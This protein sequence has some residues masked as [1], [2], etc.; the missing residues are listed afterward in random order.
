MQL[1]ID[2][3]VE[4]QILNQSGM[5]GPRLVNRAYCPLKTF[6]RPQLW[7][8]QLQRYMANSL[9]HK[10][11]KPVSIFCLAELDQLQNPIF[12]KVIENKQEKEVRSQF[13]H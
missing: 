7:T 4:N 8:E 11:L 13:V 9:T 12:F 1:Q 5:L 10:D 2:S 6:L 3:Y